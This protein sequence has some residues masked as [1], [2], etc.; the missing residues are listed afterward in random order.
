MAPT[1][2][3]TTTINTTDTI[4]K[5]LIDQFINEIVLSLYRTQIG[6]HNDD[7]FTFPRFEQQSSDPTTPA[8]HWQLYFKSGGLY[9]RAPSNGT[10]YTF[11]VT[12]PQFRADSSGTQVIATST[13]T[14]LTILTTETFDTNANYDTASQRF[15]P[16]VAGKY[17]LFGMVGYSSSVADKIY[18]LRIGKNGSVVA[19]AGA[20]FT[21]S[22]NGA[23]FYFQA[24][25]VLDANGSS[26]Y[27]ELL[28]GHVVGANA[29]VSAA[30]F[31]GW[32]LA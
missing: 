12:G 32:K 14:K 7:A 21:A 28:T 19:G 13:T 22:L 5:T 6:S 31:W 30:Y 10:I 25:T 23:S 4:N 15:T 26:D 27:F 11:A 18:Q 1:S 24:A 3:K 17:A 2:T 29:T 20:D 8:S 9:F 16:T